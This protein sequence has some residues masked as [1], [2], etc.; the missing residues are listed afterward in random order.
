MLI[1]GAKGFEK[2][3]LE[4]LF[5]NKHQKEI[6]FYYDLTLPYLELS[7]FTIYIQANRK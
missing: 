4:I 7:K 6:A 1:I 2:E 5:Q 3:V